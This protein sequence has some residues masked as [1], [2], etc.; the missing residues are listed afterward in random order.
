[1]YVFIYQ[2]VLNFRPELPVIVGGLQ[3]H[4]T[5]LGLVRCRIK[6]HRWHGKTLKSNDPLVFSLGWRRSVALVHTLIHTAHMC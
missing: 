1:M 6:R 5:T 4:E 2:F 3:S